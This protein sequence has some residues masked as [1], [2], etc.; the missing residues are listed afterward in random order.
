MS[1]L[2]VSAFYFFYLMLVS[3]VTKVTVK[4]NKFCYTV[5]R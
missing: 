5:A 2:P 1:L 4:L 3:F